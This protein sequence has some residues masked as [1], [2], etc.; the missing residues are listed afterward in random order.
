MLHAQVTRVRDVLASHHLSIHLVT[1]WLI[2]ERQRVQKHSAISNFFQTS[3][4]LERESVV[5]PSENRI[6]TFI[7]ET[8][9]GPFIDKVTTAFRTIASWS[10]LTCAITLLPQLLSGEIRIPEAEKLVEGLK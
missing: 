7:Y 3:S 8:V 5:I 6:L 2:W 9:G 1:G 10:D 4:F